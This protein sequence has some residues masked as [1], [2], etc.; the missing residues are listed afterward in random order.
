MMRS[1]FLKRQNNQ[2]IWDCRIIGSLFFL[3]WKM[4]GVNANVS[5]IFLF[6]NCDWLRSILWWKH[7]RQQ[8]HFS[9]NSCH[10]EWCWRQC[11]IIFYSKVHYGLYIIYLN[12]VQTNIFSIVVM[13]LWWIVI[14]RNGAVVLTFIDVFLCKDTLC[15]GSTCFVCISLY[16]VLKHIQFEDM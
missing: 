10:F 4:S 9:I 16:L 7:G 2:C 5:S 3:F 13:L 12:P 6:E 8:S 11:I 15:E 1:I 14:H